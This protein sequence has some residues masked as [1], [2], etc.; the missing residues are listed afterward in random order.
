[1]QYYERAVKEGRL[2]QMQAPS[3]KQGLV[4]L[5]EG[6]V[7]R[8]FVHRHEPPVMDIPVDV[9]YHTDEVVVVNKPP[10]MPVHH[11]G[12]YRKNTVVGHLAAFHSVTDVK[13]VHRLDRPVSGLLVMAR[14]SQKAEF[15]RAQIESHDVRKIYVARV[16]GVFPEGEVD[17]KEPLAW[18]ARAGQ[19]IVSSVAD[20]GKEARTSF[21][22]LSVAEDG[23][24]SVVECSPL[25]GRTH[26][27]RVHLQ[28]LGH[29]I[30]NDVKYDGDGLIA[31]AHSPVQLELSRPL[32]PAPAEAADAG[33]ASG[34]SA[35]Q[36]DGSRVDFNGQIESVGVSAAPGCPHCPSLA[37][38]GWEPAEVIPLWLHAQKY[39]GQGWEYECPLPDW[40]EATFRVNA[41]QPGMSAPSVVI[42]SADNMN[43]KRMRVV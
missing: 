7:I 35:E 25:T 32:S 1:V 42:T 8:H 4:P 28:H 29:P 23:R 30:A 6:E 27:I 38:E 33:E 15:F 9:L 19:T 11:A 41:L 18:D 14:T 3:D 40:A 5:K 37:P 13:P 34:Q 20:G 26:Q 12:Q 21:R 16:L 36:C 31:F 39:S 43:R 22:R 24:T 17:C 2:R 10:S